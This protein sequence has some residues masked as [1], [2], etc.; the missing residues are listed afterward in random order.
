MIIAGTE[1][2]KRVTTVI[3]TT[4][5]KTAV[6]QFKTEHPEGRIES[7]DGNMVR[8]QCECCEVPIFLDTVNYAYDS[9]SDIFLCPE[10]AKESK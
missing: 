5:I 10:C 2:V 8:A 9:E 7:V 6:K 1:P 3:E 4:D